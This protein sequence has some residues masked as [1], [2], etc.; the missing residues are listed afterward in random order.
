MQAQIQKIPKG[1][2]NNEGRKDLLQIALSTF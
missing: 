2:S 1:V